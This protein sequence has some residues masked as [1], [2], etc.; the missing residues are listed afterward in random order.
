MRNGF[1][2]PHIGARY[3]KGAL[4]AYELDEDAVCAVCGLPA[5]NAH[6]QPAKGMGGGSTVHLHRTKWGQFVVRPALIALCGSGTTGCH[7][8]VHEKRVKIE[9]VWDEPEAMEKWND[10]TFLSHGIDP[11]SQKLYN[12]GHWQIKQGEITYDITN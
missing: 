3:A 11:H 9:W 7:G 2:M 10:G 12:F 6:H 5:T 1:G 8:D 4:K